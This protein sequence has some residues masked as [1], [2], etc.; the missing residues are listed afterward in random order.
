ML[1]D[2]HP[3]LTPANALIKKQHGILARQITARKKSEDQ[4]LGRDHEQL[5]RT[6]M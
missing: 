6:I 2:K 3:K 5:R 1:K 4:D